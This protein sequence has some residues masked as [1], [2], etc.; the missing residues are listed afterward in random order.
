M[1]T[2]NFG[3]Q[4]CER[5]RRHFDAYLSNELLVETTDEVLKHLETC[6]ACEQELETRMELRDG[7]RR[8]VR[9]EPPPVELI[10]AVHKR[11]T[12]SRPLVFNG[13]RAPKWVVAL[14]CLAIALLAVVVGQQWFGLEQ[15]KRMV[16]NV[17]SLGV[18]DHI[19]CAMQKHQY[20]DEGSPSAQ[21]REK[22]GPAYAG[23][24]GVVEQRLPGFQV[25]EAHQCH[26][27]DAKRSYVHFIASGRGTILSVVL[28]KRIGES[29]PNRK[30]L[31]ADVSSGI[32]LYEVQ[33][34]GMSVAGFEAND[35]FGFVVSDGGRSEV[36]DMAASLAPALRSAL[37]SITALEREQS[38]EI[39][40]ASLFGTFAAGKSSKYARV[41]AR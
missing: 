24:L 41:E 26:G 29:L 1:N 21:L 38:P 12:R 17:L 16:A 27:P 8:A 9:N 10:E 28:T 22:L 37:P 11:L 32:N 14:S 2:L 34:E 39:E 18:G 36:L 7:L 4:R 30:S 23:L 3:T 5:I 6:E 15:G 31:V 20:R 13:L 25:L 35:Y 33:L 40:E 19:Y